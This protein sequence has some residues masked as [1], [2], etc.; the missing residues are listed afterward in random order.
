MLYPVPLHLWK[1]IALRYDVPLPENIVVTPQGRAIGF[2]A[3]V[4]ANPKIPVLITEGAKKAGAIMSAGYVA[5]ALPGVFNGYR[6]P[7]NDWGQKIGNPHLI[8]QLEAF[9]QKRQK[10][11][12]LF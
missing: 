10:D 7:K 4:I 6:Q 8:P 2:W 9:A 12:V 1:A 5:I 3:W 11:I